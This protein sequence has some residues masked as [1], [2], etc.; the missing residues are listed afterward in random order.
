MKWFDAGR[1]R[2]RLLFGRNTSDARFTHEITFHIQME[3]ERLQRDEGLDVAEAQRR[4][5]IAFG[6][7]ENYR[8]EMREARG[9]RWIGGL[10]LDFKL[11]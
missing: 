9:L 4:A 5:M 6:G 7:V 8:E 3:T 1:A 11:V 10:A 2:L